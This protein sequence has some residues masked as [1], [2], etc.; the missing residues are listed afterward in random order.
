MPGVVVLLVLLLLRLGL[1]VLELLVVV[2]VRLLNSERVWRL[3][4]WRVVLDPVWDVVSD[5]RGVMLGGR[6][7]D[8]DNLKVRSVKK[9]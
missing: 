8:A 3:E 2:R 6:G 9:S 7:L 5:R 4:D 1:Q